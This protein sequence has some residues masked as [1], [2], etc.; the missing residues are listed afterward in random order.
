[1]GVLQAVIMTGAPIVLRAEKP[2]KERRGGVRSPRS[3]ATIVAVGLLALI[4][5]G[6]KPLPQ[7]PGGHDRAERLGVRIVGRWAH[8]PAAFTQ[9]LVRV[10]GGF[11]ESTGGYGASD[12]RLVPLA[13]GS[14][15]PALRR[16]LAERYFGEGLALVGDRLVQLT[17]RE[18]TAFVYDR[19]TLEQVATFSYDTEGWGL[20][21]DGHDLIMSD[22]TDRITARS[23]VDFSVRRSVRVTL[24]GRP[25]AGLN[26]LECVGHRVYANRWRTDEILRID[27]ESG[28]VDAVIDAGALS[29]EAGPGADVL[30]GIAHE[31]GASTLYLTGKRWPELYEVELIDDSG[32]A[33]QP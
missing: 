8:D 17:W 2:W 30:N 25:V 14:A 26:E 28:R 16:P 21:F 10:A 9:G 31:P 7:P 23:P 11:C 6:G 3:A 29:A 1:M 22:G 18:R 24:D 27:P 33:V 15:P 20:C 19:A 32:R 5:C 4:A 12:V 13:R